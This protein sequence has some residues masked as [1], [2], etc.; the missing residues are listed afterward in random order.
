VPDIPAASL[1]AAERA[2]IEAAT[3]FGQDN[4]VAGPSSV[5]ARAAL[6]AAAPILAEAWGATSGRKPGATRDPRAR[7]SCRRC[8]AQPGRH[9]VTSSGARA[10]MVHAERRN[11]WC[12]AEGQA[13][14]IMMEAEGTQM[15][16]FP[17]PPEVPGA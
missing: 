10:P 17:P 2:I 14:G 8:G 4:I 6:E 16:R 1:A 7:I 13:A 11:D 12:R 5:F 9:C 3:D 15:D